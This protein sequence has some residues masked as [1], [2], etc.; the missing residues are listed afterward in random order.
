ML[1]LVNYKVVKVRKYPS[2]QMGKEGSQTHCKQVCEERLS[3]LSAWRIPIQTT[4]PHQNGDH[5][6]SQCRSGL[7]GR[8]DLE[9]P[10]SYVNSSSSSGT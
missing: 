9:I 7:V 5:Q 10:S 1:N 6:E 8:R 2:Q 3:A 4:L